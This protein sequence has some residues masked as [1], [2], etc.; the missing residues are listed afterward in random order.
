MRALRKSHLI[1]QGHY[2]QQTL[3]QWSVISPDDRPEVEIEVAE[4]R[5][6]GPLPNTWFVLIDDDGVSHT[7]MP[8][9]VASGC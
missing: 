8:T 1:R 2:E 7:V 6:Q 5:Y 3:T 9:I 4:P